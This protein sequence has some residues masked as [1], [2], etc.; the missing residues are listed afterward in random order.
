MITLQ[1][2]RNTYLFESLSDA[3]IESVRRIG[4]EKNFERGEEMFGQGQSATTLHVLLDGSVAVRVG[5]EEETDPLADTLAEAGSVLGTAS[6]LAPFV[7]NVTA[8]A[9]TSTRTL[10]IEAS[11]L[12]EVMAGSPAM[13]FE[14]MT[15]LAHRY[16]RRINTKR[17]GMINLFKAFKS[18]THKSEVYDTYMETV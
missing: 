17:V 11:D 1:A 14:V 12:N 16:L 13:G 5:S 2:L 18:Q 3:H 8:E 10:A 15:R 6:L 4:K 9:L 7:Y